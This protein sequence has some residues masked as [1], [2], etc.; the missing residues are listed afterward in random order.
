M[1][2]ACSETSNILYFT[3]LSVVHGHGQI[4][5]VVSFLTIYFGRSCNRDSCNRDTW[6]NINV[7]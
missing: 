4:D 1:S 2:L 6:T 5:L 7:G 3:F